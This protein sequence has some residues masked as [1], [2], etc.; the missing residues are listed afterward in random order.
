VNNRI[1]NIWGAKFTKNKTK[2]R[3][4]FFNVGSIALSVDNFRQNS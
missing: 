4:I 2:N 1:T 3:E